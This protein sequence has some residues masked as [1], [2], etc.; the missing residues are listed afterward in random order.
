MTAGSGFVPVGRRPS[1]ESPCR[2]P[3]ASSETGIA[4]GRC[5]WTAG[6]RG[7]LRDEPFDCV[8]L[9]VLMP[10]LDGY[11][12]L[13]HVRSDPSSLWTPFLREV[14]HQQVL[15]DQV[16]SHQRADQHAAAHD[17]QNAAGL[18]LERA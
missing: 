6:T 18:R 15:V 16:R 10:G 7:P 1:G 9:D 2:C 5:E 11:Q 8:P 17:R 4:C 12:V 14:D 13:E 3:E